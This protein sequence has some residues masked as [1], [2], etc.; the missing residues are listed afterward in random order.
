[1]STAPDARAMANDAVRRAR[2]AI[3][4]VVD[5]L[6][7]A[8]ARVVVIALCVCACTNPSA[9]TFHG[10][11]VEG[12]FV[13]RS[14]LDALAMRTQ[15]RV[16]SNYGLSHALRLR[17]PTYGVHDVIIASIART[18][19]DGRHFLGAFGTWF[20]VPKVLNF[21]PTV[22]VNV[23]RVHVTVFALI[24]LGALG[25]LA[26]RALRLIKTVVVGVFGLAAASYV[27]PR[28]CDAPLWSIALCAAMWGY[29]YKRGC[30]NGVVTVLKA[31]KPPPKHRRGRGPPPR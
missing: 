18:T 16:C 5:R 27:A 24:A 26:V 6:R 13:E 8:R 30:L 28:V 23:Y 11:C 1:M 21:I 25:A 20:R 12:K 17:K 2:R 19:R 22:F 4:D 31:L 29:A 14:A 15:G 7:D 9:E 3:D 10:A